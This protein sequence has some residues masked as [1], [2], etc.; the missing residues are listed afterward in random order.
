MLTVPT[1]LPEGAAWAEP[2]ALVQALRDPGYLW[3]RCPDEVSEIG[4]RVFKEGR[5]FFALPLKIKQRSALGALMDGYRGYASEYCQSEDRPDLC[6]SFWLHA[7]NVDQA[8]G[9]VDASG[10]ALYESM[11]LAASCFDFIIMR[12]VGALEQHYRGPAPGR[13]QFETRY[14]SHLQLNFYPSSGRQRDLLLDPHEDGL[15]FTL[16]QATAPGLEVRTRDGRFVAMD[17]RPGELLVMPGEIA[18]L[19]SGGEIEPLYH[20]VRNRAGAGERLSLMYFVNPNAS[21]TRTLRPWRETAV[22]RNVDIM[23]RVIENP[24]KFGLPP[25]PLVE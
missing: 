21:R 19:M 22:N 17:P 5:S 18:M 16:W 25:I 8:R 1:P 24:V 15:L 4:R 12:L 2:S 7:F 6:E 3:L 10:A 20:R 14:G 23:R 11:A 9:Q 13:P